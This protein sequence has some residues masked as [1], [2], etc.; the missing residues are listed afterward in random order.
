[1]PDDL[2]KIGTVTHYY[3]QISVAIIKLETGLKI[4]DAIKFQGKT[5]DLTQTVNSI[6]VDH[7]DIQ[8][9]KKGDE[10]G[11]KVDQPVK[12]KDQVYLVS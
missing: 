8:E 12:V 7:Q 5:T 11:V 6:Q 10:V 4:G 3:D 1:M 2:K 9:A